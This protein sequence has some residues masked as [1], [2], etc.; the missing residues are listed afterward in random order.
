VFFVLSKIFDLLVSPVTWAIALALLGVPFRVLLRRPDRELPRWRR[1]SPLAAATVLVVFSMEPVSN[2]LLRSL[3]DPPLRTVKDGVTYDVVVLLGGV[4][5]ER[6]AQTFGVRS[7]NEA[8]ER[9]LETYDLLRMNRARY[10]IVSG[11]APA[12][13]GIQIVEA[14]A[15]R[16]QLVA[17]GIEPDRVIVEDK[18]RNTRENAV[19]SA[20]IVR[21]RGL[22]SV[23]IVTSAFHMKR[24]LGCFHAVGL[25]VD[26]LPV[27]FRSHSQGS[28]WL[29]RAD[30]LDDSTI[31]I[32]EWTGRAVYRLRGYAAP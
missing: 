1:F 4:V 5:D 27:D 29:P 8:S 28:S 14:T 21:D 17:W 31:A 23:L 13:E 15:L 11:A 7:F 30:F 9:L 2:L 6:S 25:E 20:R 24:A 22:S 26:T 32:H 18:A 19:E 10:A 12:R 16:D 3:E